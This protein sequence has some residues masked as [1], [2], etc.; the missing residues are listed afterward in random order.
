MTLPAKKITILVTAVVLLLFLSGVA[1]SYSV[2]KDT[3]DQFCDHKLN[4]LKS[5]IGKT[6]IIDGN[7]RTHQIK[8]GPQL[9]S[10]PTDSEYPYEQF[11]ETSFFQIHTGSKEAI[12]CPDKM[13]VT[14][15]LKLI[16]K[17]DCSSTPIEE[18][19]G[20]YR[21]NVKEWECK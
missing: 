16:G 20:G 14:G 3:S 17:V 2:R 18:C 11:I 9:S 15:I 5:C 12:N 10:Y 19:W 8:Y 1:Y 4:G 7:K 13:T 21:V 6:I